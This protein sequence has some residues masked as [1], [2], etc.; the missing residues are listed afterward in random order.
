TLPGLFF[1]PECFVVYAFGA[2]FKYRVF[3]VEKHEVKVGL[4]GLAIEVS[5]HAA[6]KARPRRSA[7]E[8][9]EAP[10]FFYFLKIK[11]TARIRK[12]KPMRWFIRKLSVRNTS[13]VKT[14]KITRLMAS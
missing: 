3:G 12:T 9:G 1:F 2:E 6:R 8:A 13:R 14:V 11:Y 10:P 4:T 5:C 7:A